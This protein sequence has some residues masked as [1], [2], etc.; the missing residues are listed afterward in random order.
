MLTEFTAFLEKSDQFMWDW[1]QKVD[2]GSRDSRF[3]Q[4]LVWRAKKTGEP[5]LAEIPEIFGKV[6]S[7]PEDNGVKRITDKQ[8]A[9]A[10]EVMNSD[11]RIDQFLTAR[12]DP[13][14]DSCPYD[15][16]QERACF[17]NLLSS[18]KL[19]AVLDQIA[20]LEKEK[21]SCSKTVGPACVAIIR[22]GKRSAGQDFQKLA[23]YAR[24]H[25][26]RQ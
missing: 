4:F 15:V 25:A 22:L 19:G 7:E 17:Q 12:F 16:R 6:Q 18:G 13:G 3:V 11:E 21:L 24:K 26:K 2:Q 1:Y 5:T 10:N 20:A 8:L 14:L 23:E 9:N